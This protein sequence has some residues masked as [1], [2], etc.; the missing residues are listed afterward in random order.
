MFNSDLQGSGSN[1]PRNVE[2]RGEEIRKDKCN[3]SVFG[4]QAKDLTLDTWFT[5]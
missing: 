4:N 2:H 3:E 5:G 1:F